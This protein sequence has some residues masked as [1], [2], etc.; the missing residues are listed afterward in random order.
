[1]DGKEFVRKFMNNELTEED[2]QSQIQESERGAEWDYV[3]KNGKVYLSADEL[4]RSI[5]LSSRTAG[6]LCALK[7]DREGAIMAH[8]MSATAD[9]IKGANSEI[10]RREATK[11]ADI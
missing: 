11:I 8:G 9:V 2:M 1:M 3:V 4:I 7:G 10:L 5:A 6:L